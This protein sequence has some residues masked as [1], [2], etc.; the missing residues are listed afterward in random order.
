M[1]KPVPLRYSQQVRIEDGPNQV[2]REDAKRRITVGFNVRGRDVQSIVEELQGKVDAQ[3]ALPVGYYTTYGG[4]FENLVEPK[5]RLMVVVPL[6]LL[7]ILLLL[8]FAFGSLKL[9]LLVFSAVPLSAI[10]GV[11]ALAGTGHALQ[12][13]GGC[14]LHRVVRCGGAQRHRA[15]QRV[16]APGRRRH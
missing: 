13:L 8:Y 12:H 14:G 5:K 7:L 1:G 10:G 11:F 2:Q 15:H 4:T 16:R 6:A 9:S 3:L